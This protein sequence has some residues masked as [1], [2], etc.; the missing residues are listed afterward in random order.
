MR[1]TEGVEVYMFHTPGTCMPPTGFVAMNAV[2]NTAVTD[3]DI[4]SAKSELEGPLSNS[5][6]DTTLTSEQ[7][8][9]LD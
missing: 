9:V 2:A 1:A 6:N 4:R 3:E 7:T 8:A 5:F